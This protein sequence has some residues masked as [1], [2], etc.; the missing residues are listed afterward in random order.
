MRPQ[1]VIAYALM[2]VLFLIAVRSVAQNGP[3]EFKITPPSDGVK[4]EN[5]ELLIA[6]NAPNGD[7]VLVFDVCGTTIAIKMTQEEA[8]N[9][10]EKTKNAFTEH[11]DRA[12]K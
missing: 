1:Q 8:Q 6:T 5:R 9:P 11:I 10:S 3:V 12:C 2:I 4:T 7:V